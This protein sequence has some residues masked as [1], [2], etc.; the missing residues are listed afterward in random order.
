[1]QRHQHEL[2]SLNLYLS[3][4]EV[5]ANEAGYLEGALGAADEVIKQLVRP[6]N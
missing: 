2:N 6:E 1:M 5:S 3:A 4:S